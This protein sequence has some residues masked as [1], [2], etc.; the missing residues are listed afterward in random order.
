MF[1]M[2][3]P[4]LLCNLCIIRIAA[5]REYFL[6]NILMLSGRGGRGRFGGG[7]RGYA[8]SGGDEYGV[9]RGRSN[10]YQRAPH[11]ERGILGSHSAR[12]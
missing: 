12:N 10:G 6:T 11:Q 5:M 4:M 8:R 2:H 7:G 9:N 3:K 1:S